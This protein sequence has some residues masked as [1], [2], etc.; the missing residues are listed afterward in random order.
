MPFNIR[1]V[2]NQTGMPASLLCMLALYLECYMHRHLTPMLFDGRDREAARST[3]SLRTRSLGYFNPSA[4]RAQLCTPTLRPSRN[5][6]QIF[7]RVKPDQDAFMNLTGRYI[8]GQ[9]EIPGNQCR[10][11]TSPFLSQ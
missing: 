8:T 1:P 5:V 6:H 9:D 4:A 7:F 3:V 11:Y 10:E 2:P